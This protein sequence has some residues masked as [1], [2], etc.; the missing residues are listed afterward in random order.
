[1]KQLEPSLREQGIGAIYLYGSVA[2]ET[3]TDSSD[4]DL[5]FDIA[6]SA[7]ERF[8]LI[9]Q[10]RIQRQLAAALGTKVDLVERDYLRPRF[11]VSAS[12]ICMRH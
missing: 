7:T 12:V 9:D 10:A 5:A 6:P 8:S 2:R 11:A 1:M 4:V 3:Q